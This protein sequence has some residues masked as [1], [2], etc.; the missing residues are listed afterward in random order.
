MKK[1]QS[2]FSL[3]EVIITLIIVAIG[4]L[5]VAGMQVASI[6]LAD[7]ADVRSRGAV[8]VNDIVERIRSADR[9]A[10]YTI[11]LGSTPTPTDPLSRDLYE[12]KTQLANKLPQGDGSIQ[13]ITDNACN[14]ASGNLS[15]CR[16]Y[17][18]NVRWDESRARRSAAGANPGLVNF[19]TTV[20]I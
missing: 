17:T 16:M 3:L 2:G 10:D 12:W 8:F 13:L 6:K 11:P 7:A 15:P 9:T 14:V 4:L 20:R 19:N 5:G 18:I 1:N